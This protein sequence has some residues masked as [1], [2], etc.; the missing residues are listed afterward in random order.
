MK[1][2]L[3][4]IGGAGHV[5]LPLGVSFAKKRVKTVLLDINEE[6]LKKIE[7]GIFPF[8]EKD[9]DK[10]LGKALKLGTL[11][12]S[13]KPNVI[14]QSGAILMV[15]GTPVDE[16]LNPDFN[17]LI[18]MIDKYFSYFKNGQTLILR[19]TVYPGTS[20]RVQSYFMERGKKVG[21]AFCP[22]RIVQGKSLEE[23]Q[24]LPQIISGF[25]GKTVER[26]KNLF[27]NITPRAIIEVRP[28]EAELVKLFCNAWRY[29]TFAVA[30]QFFM[31]ASDHNLDYHKIYEAMV[32]DYA[33]SKDLPSPGFAAGPCLLKD[34]MQLAAFNNNNFFL[35]HSAMLVN[36]GLPN[37]LI[38]R[39]KKGASPVSS[40]NLTTPI[41]A[42]SKSLD[43]LLKQVSALGNLKTKTIGI[44]GMAFKADSDD[45]RDS[46][47]YKLRKISLGEAKKVL[48]HDVYIKDESFHPLD[49]VLA[50]SDIL[51]LASPHKEYRKIDPKKY[52]DKQF[53]DIWNV[54]KKY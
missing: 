50:E 52:S 28:I 12:T 7:A 13:A 42:D 3:C 27:Q 14:S 36:E 54:W 29:I 24:K 43:N 16:Y 31:I 45:P 46:L 32:K 22:E 49:K 47:S 35:G 19:S 33:R 53:V 37:Y 4:I 44:L 5:G 8:K 6:W 26:V 48:C 11:F 51:I 34:T 1:Y 40:Q 15:I 38:Q 25:D 9:G 17:G 41:L 10:E 18:K 20:E 30:N 21:V 39:L 23:L 2:D